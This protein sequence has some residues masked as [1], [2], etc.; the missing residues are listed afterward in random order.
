MNGGNGNGVLD[1]KDSVYDHLSLWID[2][3][4][5][6]ISEPEELHSLQEMGIFQ[7]DL[8]YH[9]SNYVDSNGNHFRYKARV[10]DNADKAHDICY[11]VFLSMEAQVASGSH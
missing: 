6:G 10:W 5:N 1:P 8:K 7:I 9:R 3:N 4:H 2:A 11:D